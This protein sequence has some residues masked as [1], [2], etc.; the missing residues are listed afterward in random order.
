[1][2]YDE[3]VIYQLS[4]KLAGEIKNLAKTIPYNWNIGEVNQIIRSSD[5]IHSNI[6]EGW[7]RR[8][9]RRD[10]IRFL[11]YSLGSSD[12]TQS[13]LVAL[14]QGKHIIEIDYKKYWKSYKDLSIKILNYINYQKKRFNIKI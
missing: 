4:I 2:H 12:E 8:F 6:T 13:H 11:S 10:F 3:L 14:Y 1:M 7:S 5:S 9:Y